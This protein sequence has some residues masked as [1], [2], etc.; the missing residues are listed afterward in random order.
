M[1]STEPAADQPAEDIDAD[2]DTDTSAES[3]A[4]GHGEAAKY[5]R[6]LRDTEAQL[7]AATSRLGVLQRGEIERLAA[8]DLVRPADLWLTGTEVASLLDEAGNV[9]AAKV[10]EAAQAAVADRPHWRAPAPHAMSGKPKERLRGGGD[11]TE[12]HRG[13]SWSDMVAER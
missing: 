12:D 3:G 2:P 7:Q 8:A 13:P 4:D 1:S 9:D 10:T 6:R 5:R 11:P